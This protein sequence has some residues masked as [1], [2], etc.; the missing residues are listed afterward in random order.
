MP[1]TVV[2]VHGAFAES[3]SW[4]RIIPAELQH[5]MAQRAR[6]HR[7]VAVEGAPHA[8]A[9]SRPDATVQLILEAAALGV[10]A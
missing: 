7:T 3:A 1:P 2:F 6:A 10:A 8:V 9:V 4:D 5:Y